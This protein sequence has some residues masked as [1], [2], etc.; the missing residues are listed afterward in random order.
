MP[1]VVCKSLLL[2]PSQ[3]RIGLSLGG[4][5]PVIMLSPS[6]PLIFCHR[7][8][9]A[10]LVTFSSACVFWHGIGILSR[11]DAGC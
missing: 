7:E 1:T 4:V 8:V 11:A 6:F 3:A 9:V 2:E 5:S 10:K